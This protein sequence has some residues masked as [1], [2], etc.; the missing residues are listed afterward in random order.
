MD[1]H[2]RFGSKA[3]IRA[4]TSHVRFTPDSGHS[5]VRPLTMRKKEERGLI[6]LPDNP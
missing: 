6:F 1:A 2:V 5:T 3:D 4:A